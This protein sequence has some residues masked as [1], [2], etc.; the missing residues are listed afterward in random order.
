MMLFDSSSQCTHKINSL[1]EDSYLVKLLV[2]VD[3]RFI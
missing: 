1:A 3:Q 2:P